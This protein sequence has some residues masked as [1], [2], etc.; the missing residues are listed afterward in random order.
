MITHKDI[1]D[2]GFIYDTQKNGGGI[3]S[4]YLGD[5]ECFILDLEG[6][7]TN[8]NFRQEKT[9]AYLMISLDGTIDLEIDE[10]RVAYG[11]SLETK[12]ELVTLLCLCGINCNVC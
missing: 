5:I 3:N 8:E 12:K 9:F 10:T 7:T 4:S 11:F 6:I 2:V 1:V